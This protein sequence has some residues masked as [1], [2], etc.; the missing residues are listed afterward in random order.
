MA[1][2]LIKSTTPSKKKSRIQLQFDKLSQN[3]ETRQV[4]VN[5]LKESIKIILPKVES[6]LR[7]LINKEI[8]GRKKKLFRLDELA[9][10]LGIKK[11]DQRNFDEYMVSEIAYL[12]PKLTDNSDNLKS[13][14]Q[15]YAGQNYE[16]K[17]RDENQ[18]SQERIDTGE[19]YF[20]EDFK[21]EEQ[22]KQRN[23]ARE[24]KALGKSAKAIYL[25]LMKRF[26]P[27]KV[28]DTVL[29]EEYNEI[30]SKIT[31]A[32]QSDNFLELLKLQTEY[33]NDT[34]TTDLADEILKRHIKLLEQQ[35]QELDAE[36][37]SIRTDYEGVIEN[38]L[39][40]NLQ[41]SPERFT[42]MKKDLK[43]NVRHFEEDFVVSHRYPEEW[44]QQWTSAIIRVVTNRD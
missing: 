7:P 42:K 44:F 5:T 3:L 36:L 12:I 28:Q 20:E 10:E 33:L 6:E 16:V 4:Q 32:H 1:E 9:D 29:K 40:K 15:K 19:N 13:L 41:F 14:Y 23:Q 30:S 25:K 22:K 34:E 21:R 8:D 37:E 35:L 11:K 26:H 18:L 43:Q 2:N 24:E 17:N 39:D 31:K 27:D 38:F